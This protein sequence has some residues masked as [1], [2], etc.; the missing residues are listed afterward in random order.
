MAAAGPA[1]QSPWLTA[2]SHRQD[3]EDLGSAA[4]C[5]AGSAGAAR[6]SEGQALAWSAPGT[7]ATSF[8]FS[9]EGV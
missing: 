7:V 5:R 6:G 2:S 8:L 3:A 1:Q 9:P 4:H